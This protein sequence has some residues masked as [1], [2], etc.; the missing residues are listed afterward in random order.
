MDVTLELIDHATGEIFAQSEVPLESLPERFAG[1][2]TTLSVGGADWHV[3]SAD[4]ETRAEMKKAGRVQLVLRKV[5]KV[6]PKDILFSLPTLEDALPAQGAA[7][8]EDVS[9]RL[10]GDDWRQVEFVHA[11]QRA[12]V[13]EE[14][15]DIAKVKSEHRKGAGFDAIHVRKRVPEPLGGV[16]LRV[17]EVERALGAKAR[18]WAVRGGGVVADGFAV[19]DAEAV[20]YGVARDGFVEALCVYGMLPDVIGRLH[21]L[22]LDHGLMLVDWCAG[23]RLRAHEAGFVE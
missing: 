7:P 12:L 19:P 21:P 6:S 20:V 13:D 3:V 2:E 11:S 23:Q 1:M 5:E 4:P 17:G 22:A 10:H 15:A 18:P 9:I 8:G 14:L 16:K